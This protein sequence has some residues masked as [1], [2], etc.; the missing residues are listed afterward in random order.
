MSKV[1]SLVSGGLDSI[2]ATYTLLKEGNE[3]LMLFIDYGQSPLEQELGAS[4][5]FCG[6]FQTRFGNR[7]SFLKQEVR[8]G[9]SKKVE[10]TWGR[11]LMFIGCALTY[12]YSQ[13]DMYYDTIGFGG[14][15][16]DV[17]LDCTSKNSK[18]FE[19]VVSVSTRGTVKLLYPI[20]DLT[21]EDIGR[22][23]N[24]YGLSIDR[25]FNCYW[26]VPCGYKSSRGLDTYRC[27]GC[28]RKAVAMKAYGYVE[29]YTNRPNS[30]T[31]VFH[32]PLSEE[33]PL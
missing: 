17:G 25:T 7:V 27:P 9:G 31:T 24:K 20:A 19:E 33:A 18:A 15:I 5:Y 23:Y 14:H 1:I 10:C 6:Q 4:K 3:V 32:H 12:D 26:N 29:K 16:T 22:E 8:L 28:R 13:V 30:P 2:L 21:Q 11:T